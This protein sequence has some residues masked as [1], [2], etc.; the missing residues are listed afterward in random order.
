M[1]AWQE[2]DALIE[3]AAVD[4]YD[5]HEQHSGFHA[6]IEDHLVVPSTRPFWESG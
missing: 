2:L 4:T 1:L 6:V 5:R 3:E